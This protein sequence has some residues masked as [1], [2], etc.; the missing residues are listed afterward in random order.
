MFGDDPR[1][2]ARRLGEMERIARDR[3]CGN[4]TEARERLRQWV[5]QD[6]CFDQ[7]DADRLIERVQE[8]RSNCRTL[9]LDDPFLR[10]GGS[11]RPL[12]F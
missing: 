3:C 5:R 6:R 11:K 7:F 10:P 4:Q 1:D 2:L 9:D 12:S 8:A